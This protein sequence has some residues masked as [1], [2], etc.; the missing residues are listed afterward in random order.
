MLCFRYI[1]TQKQFCFSAKAKYSAS[2]LYRCYIFYLIYTTNIRWHSSILKT[3]VLIYTR[4][5]NFLWILNW[6]LQMAYLYMRSMNFLFMVSINHC[7]NIWLPTSFQDLEKY[8][9]DLTAQIT[10]N[11]NIH[12]KYWHLTV[13]GKQ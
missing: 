9:N 1:S 2:D 8:G 4:N 7:Y 11:K 3:T 10:I 13:V 5:K 12:Q 6:P